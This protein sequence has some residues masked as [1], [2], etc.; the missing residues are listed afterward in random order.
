MANNKISQ[1]KVG[2]VTYDVNLPTDANPTIAGL[3]VSGTTSLKGLN[4]NGS[5][6]SVWSDTASLTGNSCVLDFPNITITGNSEGSVTITNEGAGVNINDYL[7]VSGGLTVSGTTSLNN[8]Y[9]GGDTLSIISGSNPLLALSSQGRSIYIGTED[10]EKNISL[11]TQGEGS[12]ITLSLGGESGSI[13]LNANNSDNFV[14]IYSNQPAEIHGGL[15]IYGRTTVSGGLTVSG[16]QVGPK[17]EHNIYLYGSS[18]APFRV[19]LKLINTSN[20]AITTLA[21]LRTAINN[22]GFSDSTKVLSASGTIIGST[23]FD[24]VTGV[25]VSSGALLY[26]MYD[27]VASLNGTTMT[28]NATFG[29]SPYLVSSAYVSDVVVII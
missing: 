13:E 6:L 17:Y 8:I 3:T 24:I 19:T 12:V 23:F 28:L 27:P 2:G 16:Y 18:S 26:L 29:S 1:L 22:A 20:T 11:I 21:N 4:V 14:S 5:S 10:A 15:D 9:I 7:Q 25:Y